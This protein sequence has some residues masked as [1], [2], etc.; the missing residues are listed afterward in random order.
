MYKNGL[1]ALASVSYLRT[2]VCVC[3]PVVRLCLGRENSATFISGISD[4]NEK[5]DVY[6]WNIAN[7]RFQ[8]HNADNLAAILLEV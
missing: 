2:R 1:S 8:T 7:T 4:K 3:G 5:E 6:I